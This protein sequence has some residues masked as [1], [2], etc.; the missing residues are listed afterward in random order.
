MARN[1]LICSSVAGRGRKIRTARRRCK[2]RPDAEVRYEQPGAQGRTAPLG[3]TSHLRRRGR[4]AIVSHCDP[5]IKYRRGR[6]LP[7]EGPRRRSEAGRTG[8]DSHDAASGTAQHLDKVS[9]RWVNSLALR[10][11]PQGDP[12][13]HDEMSHKGFSRP[14]ASPSTRAVS[15]NSKVSSLSVLSM[16]SRTPA[17]SSN[18]TPTVYRLIAI[19]ALIAE[20][21]SKP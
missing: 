3:D 9:F 19:S 20:C 15:P 5:T 14:A 1:E 12:G 8:A 17:C 10:L 11:Q 13:R 6:L 4:A 21:S 7:L 16:S 18:T 2:P